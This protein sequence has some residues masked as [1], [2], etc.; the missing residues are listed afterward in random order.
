M[1]T[2]FITGANGFLGNNLIRILNA[3]NDSASAQQPA[4]RVR[5]LVL[6]GSDVTSLDGLACQTVT[7]DITKPET[8]PHLL[9]PNSFDATNEERPCIVHCAGVIDVKARP[10]PAVF[11]VDVQG[12]ANMIAACECFEQACGVRPWFVHV[13]SVHAIPEKPQ[14]QQI[15]EPQRFDPDEIIG[16]YAKAKAKAARM[17]L[18]A[19]HE[20]RIDGCVV[21][22]SG[23]IGPF[24]FSPESMKRLMFDV[25]KGKLPAC[26]QGGYDFADVRDV[27]QG[28][29]SACLRGES[30]QSYILSNQTVSIKEICDLVC[31][32]VGRPHLKLN[33]P[34]WLARL[35]TPFT[36]AYY[37]L[38]HKAPLYTAYA[39]HTL[40][41]NSNFSHEKAARELGYTTRPLEET[42][43]DMM[44][45][46]ETQP[47][48]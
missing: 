34:A 21:L 29:A 17:V 25:A 46:M 1:K 26:V 22:P 32:F 10:N 2:Y 27:A 36:E 19:A 41:S 42:V 13:G 18:D 5:A 8:L 48:W 15:S 4:N 3:N 43:F 38:A 7:G 44:A 35:C 12:T 28:I 37:A 16:Q 30:G 33:V 24:D 39:L 31:D 11:A 14:G 45:W 6:E 47:G 20:G 9:D 40:T 23:L